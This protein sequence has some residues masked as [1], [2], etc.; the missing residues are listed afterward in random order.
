MYKL[1]IRY[2]SKEGYEFAKSVIFN[3][4]EW[5]T[6]TSINLAEEKGEYP[7]WKNS[8]WE[9]IGVKIRNSSLLSI[10]PTGTISF[11]A[12]TSGGCE[13]NFG[14]TYSR[15]TYDGNIY[16]ITNEIFKKTLEEKSLY[17]DELMKTIEENHGSCQGI[18]SIPKKIRDIFVTAHD[19]TPE[20]HV[21][22]V[23]TLQE[24]VDLSLSKTVNFSNNATVE[25]IFNIYI[26]AWKKRLKGLSVYR[27]GCRENQTLATNRKPETHKNELVLDY[28]QPVDKRKLGKTYGSTDKFITA[29]GS[30]Y[31]TINRDKN[32]NIVETFV[33]TSKNGTCKSNIDGLNRMISLALRSGVQVEAIIKQLKGIS[34]SACTRV[35]LKKEKNINGMSCPDI[36]GKAL[37]EEYKNGDE[38]PETK[39]NGKKC[40]ECDYILHIDGGCVA[41]NNC[42]YSKCS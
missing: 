29:C 8:E 26:Y 6:N 24:Y 13:P 12:N 41:C 5:A 20:E 16:F 2:N 15:R 31:L 30:F 22:M 35:R 1:N 34:C 4:K 38:E 27:D 37:L 36:I 21:D 11:I 7:E 40:P 17:S 19:L 23:S 3:M 14:L 28:I 42:G 32:G 39:A 10:A 9:K 18:K 33:N 25:D